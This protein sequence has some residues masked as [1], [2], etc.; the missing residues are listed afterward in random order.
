MPASLPAMP[1]ALEVIPGVIL[2]VGPSTIR[3]WFLFLPSGSLLHPAPA[4]W[5]NSSLQECPDGIE[6]L[7]LP[8]PC[9]AC[10]NIC[11]PLEIQVQVVAVAVTNGA[12][13][14]WLRLIQHQTVLP[15]FGGSFHAPR[16]SLAQAVAAPELMLSR[17][18]SKQGSLHGLGPC[19]CCLSPGSAVSTSVTFPRLLRNRSPFL[20][21]IFNSSASFLPPFLSLGSFLAVP[22]K[23][24][25]A[26]SLLCCCG[27]EFFLLP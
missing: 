9:S 15:G 25:D 23:L 6:H 19:P 27:V 10:T 22:L 17:A 1:S 18:V 2:E 13:I 11:K 12:V 4:L 5:Q 21:F 7:C 20:C 26:V 24:G 8:L 3:N 14:C 16:F